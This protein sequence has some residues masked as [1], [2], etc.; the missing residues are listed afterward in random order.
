[1]LSVQ[2][3]VIDI[4]MAVAGALIAALL[5]R[6]E[7]MWL[8]DLQQTMLVFDCMLVVVLFPAFGI[9]QSW[10]GMPMF[11]LMWR[12]PVAWLVVEGAGILMSFSV[13]H[14]SEFS[15]LWLGYWAVAT[16]ALLVASKACVY[17]VLRRLRRGGYNHKAVAI[18]GSVHA[19]ATKRLIAYMCARPDAGFKPVC[20]YDASGDAVD[21]KNCPM[22]FGPDGIVIERCF[23][24]LVRRV[25][26]RE[27][28]ELWLVLP[29]SEEPQI[30]RIVTEFRH[31]FVNIRFIPDVRSVSLFNQDVVELLGVPAINLAASP[32]TDMRILPKFVFDR[33]FALAALVLLA[34]VMLM[35]A[36]LVK[37]TSPGPVFFRQKRK[38]VDGGEFEIYKFRSM[39]VHQEKAGQI[40]QAAKNDSRVTPVG[41]FLRRTSLDELPQF[42]NVLKGEMSVVG[43]RPH[44][45]EHDDIYK[46]LVNGYMFR[47]RI[48]PGIT[49]W[50][51][52]N[53]FRG[54]TAR[55]EQMA[56]R[57]KL[58][59]YYMQNWSLWLDIKIVALTLWKGFTCSN[60]Y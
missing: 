36:A 26:G 11:G 34:P 51:Q 45:L 20:I 56:A 59:L 23:A 39:K 54:E 29:L 6:R 30:Q 57:V 27:I 2:A 43:P 33:M 5:Y 31:D 38:G 19:A 52:I 37:S 35:I 7:C 16:I 50:A 32:I 8:D 48:K 17:A 47:Y 22:P 25:R 53:G 55:I 41:R 49:G 15:Y 12:V 21:A 44:A 60:A 10:R 28:R 3:R 42:I 46:D 18:V 58:D 40:T 4:A 24:E 1:M 9:Y 14:A 13:H